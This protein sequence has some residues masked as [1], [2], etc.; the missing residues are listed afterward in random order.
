MDWLKCERQIED[1]W[2]EFN[3]GISSSGVA[4]GASSSCRV[5]GVSSA[6][7]L[8]SAA[9]AAAAAAVVAPVP[10]LPLPQPPGAPAPARSPHTAAGGKGRGGAA[11]KRGRRDVILVNR[12]LVVQVG[13]GGLCER[14]YRHACARMRITPREDRNNNID[15]DA[16]DADDDGGGGGCCW[17]GSNDDWDVSGSDRSEL[18][19]ND[20]SHDGGSGDGDGDGDGR[21][22][23]FAPPLPLAHTA[24]PAPYTNQQHP[25]AAS[26][27][28]FEGGG[29]CT[30]EDPSNN[31]RH[32]MFSGP[33][34]LIGI[35]Q[36]TSRYT[37]C[38]N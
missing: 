37:G 27:S 21:L 25:Q 29:T 11:G 36:N 18:S 24:N 26:L 35:L 1:F 22:D 12:M 23:G 20:V 9:A 6:S 30:A 13:L 28:V 38:L 2:R 5:G 34:P 16:D 32:H 4:S 19:D 10:P 15:A 14:F 8:N 17:G 33:N 3:V 7:S 31:G